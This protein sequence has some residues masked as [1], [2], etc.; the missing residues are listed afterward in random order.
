MFLLV[1]VSGC[2]DDSTTSGEEKQL[3][4][5]RGYIS[6]QK[7]DK[8]KSELN[9]HK[10]NEELNYYIACSE[11]YVATKEYGETLY[12]LDYGASLK[13]TLGD[14]GV[15]KLNTLIDDILSEH[16][17]ELMKTREKERKL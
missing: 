8:A 1:F 14:K 3:V 9:R 17:S 13:H 11:Y 4:K 7:Y 5:I 12:K 6:E 15:K 16:Q 2:G 10:F